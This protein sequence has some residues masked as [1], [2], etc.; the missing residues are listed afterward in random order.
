MSH[1]DP[2]VAFPVG[3]LLSNDNTHSMLVSVI[4]LEFVG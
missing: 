3:I 2:E 4:V 1:A